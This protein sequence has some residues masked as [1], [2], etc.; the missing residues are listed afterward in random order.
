LTLNRNPQPINPEA[1][2]PT[3][4]RELNGRETGDPHRGLLELP[5]LLGHGRSVPGTPATHPAPY[6]LHPTPLPFFS[7]NELISATL[8][9]TPYL[10]TPYTLHPTPYTL[11][12][13]PYTLHPTPCTLHPAPCTLH[14][15]PYTLHPTPYIPHPTPYTHRTPHPKPAHGR[16]GAHDRLDLIRERLVGWDGWLHVRLHDLGEGRVRERA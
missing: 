15:T 6:T 10:H 16:A 14:P 11:H 13:A 12:P 4:G 2:P 3:A 9:P 7:S 5:G 1:Q 8:L